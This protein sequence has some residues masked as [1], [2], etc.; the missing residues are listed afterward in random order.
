MIKVVNS[1]LRYKT[2]QGLRLM[3]VW[4]KAWSKLGCV[5]GGY[6]SRSPILLESLR[7]HSRYSF[8][9]ETSLLRHVKL[10]VSILENKE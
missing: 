1:N 4:S 3:Q 8:F 9:F 2:K 7:K 6:E 5:M 10:G